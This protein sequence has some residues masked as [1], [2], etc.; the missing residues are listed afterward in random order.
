MKFCC[1]VRRDGELRPPAVCFLQEQ[2]TIT[3]AVS[4]SVLER[5]TM[6]SFPNVLKVHNVLSDRTA[7][8]IG[9]ATRNAPNVPNISRALKYVP[10][11]TIMTTFSR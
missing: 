7:S 9:S 5:A 2:S 1:S 4:P 3:S 11:L 8:G 6:T 10:G